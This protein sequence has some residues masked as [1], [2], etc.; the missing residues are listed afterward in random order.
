MGTK[1]EEDAVKNPCQHSVDGANSHSSPL[2]IRYW[3]APAQSPTLFHPQVPGYFSDSE[4][5]M[6]HPDILFALPRPEKTHRNESTIIYS[7]ED[8]AKSS[9]T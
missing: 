6:S 3:V 9:S 1:C 8:F 2:A 7:L 4:D 5:V